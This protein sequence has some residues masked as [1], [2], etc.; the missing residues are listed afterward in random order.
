M[1]VLSSLSKIFMVILYLIW[2]LQLIKV[3]W[4]SLKIEKLINRYEMVA[5]LKWIKL[6][7]SNDIFVNFVHTHK[8]CLK[9]L[10]CLIWDLWL[11][12]VRG[13]FI[14]SKNNWCGRKYWLCQ[15]KFCWLILF[16]SWKEKQFWNQDAKYNPKTTSASC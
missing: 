15:K 11:S 16:Q 9:L 12:E 7:Y 13:K 5:T 4:E 3:R 2:D 6:T 10:K 1:K 14:V 8:V